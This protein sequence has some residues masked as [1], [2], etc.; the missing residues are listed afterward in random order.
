MKKGFSLTL[1]FL[2]FLLPTSA[3]AFQNEPDGFR[4]I[5]WGADLSKRSDMSHIRGDM[6]KRKNDK[7]TIGEASLKQVVYMGYKGRLKGMAISYEDSSNS[8]QLKSTFFQ[9][10]GKGDKP[11]R[12]IEEYYWI[13]SAVAIVLTYSEITK[14]GRIGYYYRPLCKKEDKEMKEAAKSG[15]D[16]L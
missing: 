5:K 7:L 16:D 15:A 14:E 13:G 12:F 8:R 1:I 6:Y 2:V 9:L 3:L 11:N 10:Y 4:G